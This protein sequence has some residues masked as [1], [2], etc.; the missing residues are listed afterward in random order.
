MFEECSSFLPV[1]KYN[2]KVSVYACQSPCV[3]AYK[4]QS[5][6]FHDA[7]CYCLSL[8][9]AVIM[10]SPCVF[11]DRYWANPSLGFIEYLGL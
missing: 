2:P 9:P 6:A 1:A 4:Q 10:E 8:H 11:P 7:F 5:S 3:S